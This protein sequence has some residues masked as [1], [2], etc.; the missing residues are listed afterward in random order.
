VSQVKPDG[1]T[2][3]S[4]GKSIYKIKVLDVPTSAEQGLERRGP[5]GNSTENIQITQRTKN[6]SLIEREEPTNQLD[7]RKLVNKSRL[8]KY[9]ANDE[10]E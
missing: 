9:R 2:D 1:R 4:A 3:K 10:E 5:W 7:E 8:F 6:F